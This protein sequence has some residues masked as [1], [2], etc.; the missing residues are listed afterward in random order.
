MRSQAEQSTEGPCHEIMTPCRFA[1]YK[2][3]L[4]P[5]GP[6]QRA[7]AQWFGHG[8]WV[9]NWGLKRSNARGWLA[10][11]PASCLAQKLRDLD[12]AYRNAFTGRARLPRFKSRHGPQRVRVAF[13][14]RHHGKVRAW[15]EDR[16]VLPG[17]KAVKLR[18]RALPK[19]VTVSLDPCG[20]YWVSFAVEEHIAPMAPA[21]RSSVGVALG[22]VLL[23]TLSNGETIENP[24]TLAKRLKQLERLQQRLARQCRGSNRRARTRIRIAR[25]Y[26]RITDC[27]REH[28]HRLTHRLVHE[29]QVLTVEDL[30][31]E[32]MARSAMGNIEAE[33]LRILMYPEDSGPVTR[34]RTRAGD[35]RA[36]GGEGERSNVAGPVAMSARIDREV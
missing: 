34:S 23:A 33:D 6:Q 9:W 16:M 15:L 13:D 31:A 1:A 27:R 36:S 8:R 4:Y 7:L 12:T 32:G 11:A 19:L 2:V 3:R 14:H 22:V 35:T 5:T 26:A 18:G 21:R 10:E 28:L 24:R 17:I 30:N 25:L 29:N 20:R